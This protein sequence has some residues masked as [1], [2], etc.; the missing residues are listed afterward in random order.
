MTAEEF[1]NGWAFSTFDIET[2]VVAALRVPR[3][4]ALAINRKL[5]MYRV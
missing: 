3:K 2:G 1:G 5:G 4:T